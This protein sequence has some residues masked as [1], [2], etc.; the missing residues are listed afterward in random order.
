MSDEEIIH[1]SIKDGHLTER[2]IEKIKEKNQY[3]KKERWT[4]E[5]DRHAGSQIVVYF[6]EEAAKKFVE[7][8]NKSF[9]N[10]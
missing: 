7:E 6:T 10:A 2:Q 4:I 9:N 1:I 8:V 3:P 5:F